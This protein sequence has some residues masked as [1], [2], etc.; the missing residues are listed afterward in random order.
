M[1]AQLRNGFFLVRKRLQMTIRTSR[2]NSESV[3]LTILGEVLS[4]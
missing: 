2:I 1:T 4:Q 3:I